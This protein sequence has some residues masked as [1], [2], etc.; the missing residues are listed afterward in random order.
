MTIALTHRERSLRTLR[1]EPV[2]RVPD[3]EFGA[4]T[5]TIDR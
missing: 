4:W 2:D 5:Q 1:H 3:Y